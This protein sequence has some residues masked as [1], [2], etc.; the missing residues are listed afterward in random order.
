[1]NSQYLPTLADREQREHDRQ[2]AWTRSIKA[3]ADLGD[4]RSDEARSRF[5]ASSIVDARMAHTMKSDNSKP[6]HGEERT[7]VTYEE[8]AS[9]SDAAL[10]DIHDHCM[11]DARQDRIEEE[12]LAEARER[13]DAE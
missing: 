5:V 9:L 11:E 1:M 6:V 2:G 4:K 8:S 12:R 13:G 3:L 7:F 10:D